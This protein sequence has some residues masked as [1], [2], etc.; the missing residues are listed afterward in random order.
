M[1]S[2]IIAVAVVTLVSTIIG[3]VVTYTIACFFA[4][5]LGY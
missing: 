2:I 5:K 1:L 3:A 4:S